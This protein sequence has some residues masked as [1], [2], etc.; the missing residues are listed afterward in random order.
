[1]GA[2]V[3]IHVARALQALQCG[4]QKIEAFRKDFDPETELMIPG[5]EKAMLDDA[6]KEFRRLQ[7][8]LEGVVTMRR[9]SWG[10]L[11]G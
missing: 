9:R 8:I 1:M 7:K 2:I 3:E 11:T 5:N 4:F 10:S 6:A